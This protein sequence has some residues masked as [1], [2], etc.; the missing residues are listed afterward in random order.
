MGF[1]SCLSLIDCGT[2]SYCLKYRGWIEDC[3]DNCPYYSVGRASQCKE[4]KIRGFDIECI[5]LARK[6]NY[7][8]E[9]EFYCTQ[10][11]ESEPSCE[12]CD[13]AQHSQEL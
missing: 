1:K 9:I 11:E 3:P 2:N 4:Y 6:K 8:G 10:L 5:Y 7:E 13:L 12:I